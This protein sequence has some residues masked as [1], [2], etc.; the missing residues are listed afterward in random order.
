MDQY[1]VTEEKK[2]SSPNQINFKMCS[3]DSTYIVFMALRSEEK[4]FNW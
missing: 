4:T 2:Q 3:K 1:G